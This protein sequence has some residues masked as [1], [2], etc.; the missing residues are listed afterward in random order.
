MI[1]VIELCQL[2]QAL[3]IR[4]PQSLAHSLNVRFHLR[5]QLGLAD[6][7]DGRVLVEQT[8]VVEV[9]EFAEDA[10]LRELGDTRDEGELQVWV[11]LLQGA[12]EVLHDAAERLQVFLFMYHIQQCGI[13]FVYDD[14]SLFARLL[15]S[16]LHDTI[17]SFIR[18][19][20]IFSFTIKFF[21][22]Q[23]LQVQII[24]QGICIKVLGTAHVEVEHRMLHPILLVISNGQSLEQFLSA[25]EIGLEG[26]GKE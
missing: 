20:F 3:L 14:H 25:L 17:Q 12:V 10:E 11:E 1:T 16:P 6:T 22:G 2:F 24:V 9:V 4:Q 18:T 23:K 13:I 7:A 26:R 19:D 21:V 8:D 15:V 5:G